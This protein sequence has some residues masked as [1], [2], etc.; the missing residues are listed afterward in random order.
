M[1]V[2][3]LPHWLVCRKWGTNQS[4]WQASRDTDRQLCCSQNRKVI[5]KKGNY[6]VRIKVLAAI[7]LGIQ[8]FIVRSKSTDISEEHLRLLRLRTRLSD[9]LGRYNHGNYFNRNFQL[10]FLLTPLTV[11][12]YANIPQLKSRTASHRIPHL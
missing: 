8:R 11:N 6:F 3:Q 2:I 4:R 7:S 1:N 9:Y 12:I 10:L 5:R